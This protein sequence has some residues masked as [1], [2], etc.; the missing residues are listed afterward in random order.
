MKMKTTVTVLAL[1]VGML[2]VPIATAYGQ[3]N[4]PDLEVQASDITLAPSG[5]VPLGGQVSIDADI[6]NVENCYIVFGDDRDSTRYSHNFTTADLIKVEARV[7][8]TSGL[9]EGRAFVGIATFPF[10][11]SSTSWEIVDSIFIVVPPTDNAGVWIQK[12]DPLETEPDLEIDWIQVYKAT[13]VGVP[14]ETT[15]TSLF[16]R[17]AEDYQAGGGSVNMIY[18][19][20]V[21]V[22]FY[23]GDPGAGG[24]K[25]GSTQIV[26]DVQKITQTGN[27][28]ILR[29]D[30]VATAEETW[31]ADL[32]YGEHKI[33]ATILNSPREQITTNNEAFQPI[34]V[35][36]PPP[37][38][39]TLS[40][41]GLI[42][43]CG[44]L[45]ATGIA[46]IIRRKAQAVH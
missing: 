23:D 35:V 18:P 36:V 21:Q 24:D 14:P 45:L 33:Y 30:S 44:L 9:T 28:W 7:R 31:I 37:P 38:I 12:I 25:I 13:V 16:T 22:E 27:V 2:S 1:L 6:H 10:S 46:V 29:E 34:E 42:I 15:W 17:E 3:D 26:G 4:E 19:Q 41:W 20:N 43:F 11:T 40:E 39:P 5:T 32:P 8:S